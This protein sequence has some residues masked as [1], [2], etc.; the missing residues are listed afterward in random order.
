MSCLPY[1]AATLRAAFF[2]ACAIS[3]SRTQAPSSHAFL[4]RR[5]AFGVAGAVALDHGEELRPVGL[6]KS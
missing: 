2:S 3:P 6:E 4:P 1:S 5:H